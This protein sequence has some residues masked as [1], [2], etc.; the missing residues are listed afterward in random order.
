MFFFGN[1]ILAN[2][3][4]VFYDFE[5]KKKEKESQNLEASKSD[6][7]LFFFKKNIHYSLCKQN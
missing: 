1:P 6:I 3:E 2:Y 5:I 4:K 7:R